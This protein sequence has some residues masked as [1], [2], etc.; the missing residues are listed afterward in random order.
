MS[1]HDNYR[2]FNA[3]ITLSSDKK[4]KLKRSRNAVRY[5]IR[6]Y[7]RES[8]NDKAP[9]FH[10]QGS[11]A[12]GTTVNPLNGDYDIDDG[13]Y[14]QN[15]AEHKAD[16]PSVDKV[17]GW[18]IEA[19]KDRTSEPPQNK[20]NCVRVRYKDGYHVD[21]PSY[22]E[23]DSK[24][25]LSQKTPAPEWVL[26]DP[27]EFTD[28]FLNKIGIHGEQ[29]RS[30]VK[31]LKAWA[32]FKS[33]EF[34]GIAVTILAAEEFSGNIDRDDL[35]MKNTVRNI[36]IR[37]KCS[38]IISKPVFPYDDVL[39][40]MSDPQIETL[41]EYLETLLAKLNEAYE[42]EDEE[43]A[44]RILQRQYGDRFPVIEHKPRKHKPVVVTPASPRP[45]SR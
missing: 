23:E 24:Y 3:S 12:M 7:F 34:P 1:L 26:S 11:I 32:D 33:I 30:C 44:A 28:W 25:Y 15:L 43:D 4:G 45:W 16:W 39:S 9:R 19:T 40:S 18:L 22:G 37:L 38:R 8:L 42:E 29:L 20:R 27:K 17:R 10:Q 14:L 6:T 31:Y 36:L 21:L 5:D 13:V 41:L 35:A 2:K